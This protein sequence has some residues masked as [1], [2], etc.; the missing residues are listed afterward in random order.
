[1]NGSMHVY[2][3][4]YVLSCNQPRVTGQAPAGV[5]FGYIELE[6]STDRLLSER[7]LFLTV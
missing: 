1:M 2:V 5:Y 6:V 3:F 7:G 4:I